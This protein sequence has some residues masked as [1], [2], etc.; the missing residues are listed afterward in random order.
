[1]RR[2]GSWL[3]CASIGL[4]CASQSSPAHADDVITLGAAV[5]MTGKY[6][7][8]GANTRNGYDLAVKTINGKGGVIVGDKSYQLV[9][10]Y[11]DDESTPARGT[12]LAERLIKQDKVKFMLGPTAPA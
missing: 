8:N 2:A 9:I 6:A 7:Q 4:L 5:S 11:Y 1:M 12:E 10:R 3:I